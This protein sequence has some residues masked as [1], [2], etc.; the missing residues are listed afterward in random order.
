MSLFEKL[1]LAADVQTETLRLE[2]RPLSFQIVQ[3]VVFSVLRKLV[4]GPVFLLLVPFILHRVGAVGYG[5]WSIFG[6]IIGLGWLLD[7]GIGPSVTKHVAE[8]RGRGDDSQLRRLLNTS[9]ALYLVI[10]TLS[11]CV[12]WAFS[13]VMIHQL[14]RGQEAPPI[15]ELRVLW[16]LLLPIIAADLLSKP[17][18]AV[19]SGCQRMDLGNVLFFFN[20]ASNAIL[21]VVFLCAGGQLR[22]LCFAALV[23]A[24][25]SLLI[26]IVMA[27]RLLPSITPN[28]FACDVATL[29]TI[30]SFS[31][32]LYAG[33]LMTT[34]QGQVEKL[35]LARLVGVVPVGWYSMASEA[36]SKVR[37]MPDLLLGPVMAATSELDAANER[38]KVAQLYY[39]A[40]KYLAVTAV[41]LVIFALVAAKPLVSLWLGPKLSFVAV[42]FALLV[43][44]NFFPQIGAPTYFVLIGRGILR[45][46]VYAAS[47]AAILNV[48]LSFVFIR[49]WGFVGAVWGTILPM[50]I[51]TG[52]FFVASRPYF[53]TSFREMLRRAYLTPFLCSLAAAAA[54]SAASV[55]RLR[56]WLHLVAAI[57][58]Y[59]A[60]YLTGLALTRFFDEFDLAKA[61]GYASFLRVV[62]RVMPI[63]Y[64]VE[65]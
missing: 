40:H 4:I 23:S 18:I 9:C 17:F 22:G 41:P 28:P 44:G 42:P 46:T 27:H 11:V 13:G 37:R 26:S 35:Y 25:L 8:Y 49:R 30:C 12:L 6:T 14:F 43:V 56:L 47:L 21:T 36:A 61:E 32:G 15:N 29:R 64:R 54:M 7:L 62:R 63:A 20:N 33:N 31:L 3:N 10:T 48:V 59:G 45:P 60:V 55:L 16:V 34:V 39:R 1:G 52:Y 58:I 5:T 50:I 65:G 57:T 2:R 53:E 38:S 51:S 24:L 19:I